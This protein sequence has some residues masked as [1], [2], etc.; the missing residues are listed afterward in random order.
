[1]KYL[2]KFLKNINILPQSIISKKPDTVVI[3]G[4]NAEIDSV[5][6]VNFILELEMYL[7]NEIDCDLDLFHI[8]ENKNFINLKI[9]DLDTLI[10]DEINKLE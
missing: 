6:F 2:N 8:I 4:E 1:M 7:S 10:I 5:I 9:I 3:A